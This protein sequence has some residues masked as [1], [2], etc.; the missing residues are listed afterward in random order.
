[1]K[2]NKKATI[3]DIA[4]AAKVST[5][6]VSHV[7]NNTRYVSEK[8][9]HAVLEAIKSFHYIPS[10]TARSLS[11]K[12]T[13]TIGV[14]ISDLQN[15]FYGSIVRSIEENLLKSGYNILIASN[16]EN[17]LKED[18]H[19]RTFFSKGVDG[20]ILAPASE[21][22][23]ILD[24]F[25]SLG[26]KIVLIDRILEKYP[27]TSIV[28]DNKSGSKKLINHLI[29]DGHERIGVIM[30]EAI[31]AE[32]ERLNGYK[33]ALKEHD[34]PFKEE[35]VI[36]CK[37]QEY[38]AYYA[39]KYLLEN[40]LKPT[41]IFTMDNLM[42]IGALFAFKEKRLECPRDIALVGFDDP[43]WAPVSDPPLTVVYQPRIEIGARAAD[44]LLKQLN[45]EH[46]PAV[47]HLNTKIK[48]RGSCSLKCLQKYKNVVTDYKLEMLENIYTSGT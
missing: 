32:K 18:A 17:G 19:L 46:T 36:T 39:A 16:E 2:L 12:K 22:I 25:S 37:G 45:G 23:P 4:K 20:I 7:V 47:I 3:S 42:T 5:A 30:S 44:L 11:T 8:L 29:D 14:I 28:V 27:Y 15:P 26:I 13:N 40:G 34:I 6:T 33:S 21:N 1:M 9:R 10:N 48:I 31:Y 43:I 24:V 38:G 35:F 41:A